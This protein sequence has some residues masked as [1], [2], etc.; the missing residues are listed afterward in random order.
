MK[1]IL[2]IC[3]L[4]FLVVFAVSKNTSKPTTACDNSESKLSCYEDLID[5]TLKEKGLEKAFE[6]FGELFQEDPEF[7]SSCHDFAHKLGEKA[8][9]LY[10]RKENFTVSE[11]SSYCGYGFYH[12]F[13]ESLLQ[14]TSDMNEARAFCEYID[15]QLKKTTA[16]AGGA[17][18][19]GIGHGAVD[20]A[21]PRSWGDPRAMIKPALAICSMVSSDEVPSPRYGKLYRCSSGAFNG[22]EVLSTQKKFGLSINAV[23]PFWICRDQ[24]DSYKEACFT[25]FV[26]ALLN[27]T[28]N[29]FE[30]AA[31]SIDGI[32]EDTYA[33][34][35]LQAMVVEFARVGKTN[36]EETLR[37]CR[38]LSARFHIPCV[39]AFAE[40][41][42]KY[43]P[44]QKEYIEAIKFCN[45]GLLQ[46]TEK[47]SC[48]E[49]VLSL[50]RVWYTAEKSRVICMEAPEKYRW[51]N[52]E[53]N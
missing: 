53:Y 43:G 45:S 36:Y 24:P 10:S 44:P 52:C 35:I 37:F 50:L 1:K 29:D 42:L 15:K 41:F 13:M 20:G 17:C 14:K 6:Q 5:F 11:K 12:G 19:H 16:D 39:S 34:P 7:A 47:T 48:F 21:D 23:D 3:L 32:E 4:F 25:Q 22:L 51:Q 31:L 2:F 28:K 40:G 30:K 33:V 18:Y 26:V 38:G 49:R 8:Y 27:I 9:D 46:E